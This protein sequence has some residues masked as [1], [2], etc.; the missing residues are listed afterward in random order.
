MFVELHLEC[1]VDSIVKSVCG[2]KNSGGEEVEK[3]LRKLREI[4]E[5]NKERLRMRMSRRI[6]Y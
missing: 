6:I 4:E 3:R 1:F 2:G 5:E